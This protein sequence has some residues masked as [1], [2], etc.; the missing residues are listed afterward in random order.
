VAVVNFK[1]PLL[2]FAD[3]DIGVP[4]ENF[5]VDMS[6]LS[7]RDVVYTIHEQI[8]TYRFYVAVD[9]LYTRMPYLTIHRTV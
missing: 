1:S 3:K 9:C 6:S 7:L 5:E 4:A 8:K 2:L